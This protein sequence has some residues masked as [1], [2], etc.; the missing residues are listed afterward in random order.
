[1]PGEIARRIERLHVS[2]ILTR[3]IARDRLGDEREIFVFAEKV[4]FPDPGFDE[5]RKVAVLQA[6]P[7]LLDAG[8]LL[9]TTLLADQFPQRFVWNRALEMK[10]QLDLGQLVQPG[11]FGVVD[12]LH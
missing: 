4:V 2:D 10:M 5:V 8:D 9:P 7:E 6:L 1:V 11:A 3:Q 12:H